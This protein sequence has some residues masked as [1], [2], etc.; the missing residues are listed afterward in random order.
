MISELV[1]AIYR[2]P[3]ERIRALLEAGADPNEEA[4]DGFPPLIAAIVCVRQAPG[5]KKRGLDGTPHSR[6]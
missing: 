3:I 1:N 2:E 5:M 4:L 6:R